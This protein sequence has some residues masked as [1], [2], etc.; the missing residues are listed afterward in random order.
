MPFANIPATR[1]LSFQSDS[2][3]L[4]ED[5]IYQADNKDLFVVPVGYVT[6]GAS[7]PQPFWGIISPWGEAKFPGFLHD[8]LYGLRGGDPFFKTRKECDDLF[9]EAMK[10]VGVDWLKRRVIYQAVRSF[11]WKAWNGKPRL[12]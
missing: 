2:M 3:E 11:G 8:Y 4:L 1:W 7:V 10:S 12:L 6:D 5:L 9:L